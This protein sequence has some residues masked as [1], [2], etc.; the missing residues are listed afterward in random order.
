MF[1]KEFIRLVTETVHTNNNNHNNL[2]KELTILLLFIMW[3]VVKLQ[4]LS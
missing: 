3:C 1:L 4:N 2:L